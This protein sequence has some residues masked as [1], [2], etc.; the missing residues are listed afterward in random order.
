MKNLLRAITLIILITFCCTILQADA[1]MSGKSSNMADKLLQH[2]CYIPANRY[3]IKKMELLLSEQTGVKIE[4]AGLDE[5]ETFTVNQDT[6]RLK[7]SEVM[8]KVFYCNNS[9]I[10]YN[11][12]RDR[13][14]LTCLGVSKIKSVPKPENKITSNID[15]QCGRPVSDAVALRNHEI[16]LNEKSDKSVIIPGTNMT[17]AEIDEIGKKNHELY[18]QEKTDQSAVILGTNITRA[19][20]DEI[21]R[22][23]YD[24]YL[25]EKSDES[26]IIPGTNMIR[27]EIDEIGKKNHELY[28]QEK[29]DRSAVI[30][31]TN[32]TRAE[33]DEIGK[34]NF[35][36][37]A[38]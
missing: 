36:L 16:Y 22:K 13:V 26:V 34:E 25:R 12:I 9:I 5:D 29:T 2:I 6:E 15:N 27:A 28:M 14:K 7:L 35:N 37:L 32:M 30:L 21:G 8:E 31:V 19:E 10:W 17:R 4:L 24:I 11:R 20:I 23:S 3:D 33:L 38:K 18:M 1:V